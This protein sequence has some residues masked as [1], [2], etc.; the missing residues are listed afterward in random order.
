MLDKSYDFSEFPKTIESD[1]F[2]KLV[3]DIGEEK[4]NQIQNFPLSR[5][6]EVGAYVASND[7][8]NYEPICRRVQIGIQYLQH[9]SLSGD[10]KEIN[11]TIL[12]ALNN[13]A[14]GLILD[15]LDDVDLSGA[16]KG[17]SPEHCLIGLRIGE[18]LKKYKAWFKS[19]DFR[20]ENCSMLI[21]SS[22]SGAGDVVW[23][24]AKNIRLN[25][26]KNSGTVTEIVFLL[27]SVVSNLERQIK[28]GSSV[29][30]ASQNLWIETTLSSSYFLEL[31]KIR[32]LRKL[33]EMILSAYGCSHSNI[34]VH[35]NC[36]NADKNNTDE[37]NYL[38]CTTQ[39]MSAIAGGVDSM[40]I[41]PNMDSSNS[42]RIAR[43]ICNLL[44]E[45]S[46]FEKVMDP[47][48]GSFYIEKITNN[49]ARTAWDRFVQVDTNGGMKWALESKYF[50]KEIEL[51]IEFAKNIHQKID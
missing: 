49:L 20:L 25:M 7:S 24:L 26:L 41:H 19:Q 27:T 12:V 45:E 17:V 51:D 46:H 33:I 47:G 28:H 39:A 21:D 48:A 34:H 40:A 1:W 15:N 8:S 4:A 22:V 16:L 31:A 42:A 30:Q 36:Q 13:G 23:P 5:D 44:R 43:N 2:D 3:K 35:A 10:T 38:H 29:D 37:S 9:F 11:E 6:V 32:A 50:E 18:D 14:D